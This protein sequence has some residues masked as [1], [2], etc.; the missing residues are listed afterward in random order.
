MFGSPS[1]DHPELSRPSLDNPPPSPVYRLY[2]LVGGRIAG[3]AEVIVRAD[4]HG[5]I[6]KAKQHLEGAAIEV[7]HGPRLVTRIEPH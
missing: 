7:W 3:P 5:A 4:D 2:K 1:N 6:D